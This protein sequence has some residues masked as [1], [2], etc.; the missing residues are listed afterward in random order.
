MSLAQRRHHEAR[1]KRK[2]RS[3]YGGHNDP[4]RLGIYARTRTPCSCYMCGNP[5]RLGELPM[6]EL[7]HRAALGGAL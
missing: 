6:Q 5:R 2:V 3:Y 7:R 1:L 4:R